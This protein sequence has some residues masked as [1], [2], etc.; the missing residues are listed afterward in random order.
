MGKAQTPLETS[1]NN[2]MWQRGRS[3]SRNTYSAEIWPR[4]TNEE[5]RLKSKPD[6]G[7]SY[8]S[9]AENSQRPDKMVERRK[10]QDLVINRGL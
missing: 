9:V 8:P 2:R 5:G 7:S 1:H 6:G 10:T 3:M 4:A